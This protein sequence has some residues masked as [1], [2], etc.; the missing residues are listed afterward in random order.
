MSVR[1]RLCGV[2]EITSGTARPFVEAGT[3][4]VLVRIEEDFYALNDRC[5]HA[6]IALSEGEVHVEN[7]HIECWKHGSSFS[8]ETGCPDV[9]PATQPVPTYEVEVEGGSVWVVLP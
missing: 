9:L 8:L 3:K 5:S 1:A 2:D 7:R 4:I 6:N